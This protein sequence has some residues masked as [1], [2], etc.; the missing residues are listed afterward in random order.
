MKLIMIVEIEDNTSPASRK[1]SGI[2]IGPIPI[3]T[4]MKTLNADLNVTNYSVFWV[5]SNSF[6]SFFIFIFIKN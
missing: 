3:I 1:T 5:L 4:F 6:P 2:I